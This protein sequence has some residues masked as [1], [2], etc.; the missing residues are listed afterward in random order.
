MFQ[1]GDVVVYKGDDV[2]SPTLPAGTFGIVVS[3][4]CSTVL[5]EFGNN[6]SGGNQQ[7]Y[8]GCKCSSGW[9][10][11][12]RYLEKP[13]LNPFYLVELVD[14]GERPY[15]TV[16]YADG[17]EAA[18]EAKR[19]SKDLGRKIQVR[20]IIDTPI[21]WKAREQMRFDMGL[22]DPMPAGWDLIP[23]KDHFLH[24]AKGDKGMVAYTKDDQ[25]GNLDR[26]ARTT[27]GR[28][29]ERFYPDLNEQQRARFIAVISTP[30]YAIT[31][32]PAAIEIIYRNGP[33]SCMSHPLNNYQSEIHP[34]QIYGN[35]E[36]ALAYIGNPNSKVSARA[37]VRPT[38]KAFY[39]IYG[40][41]PRLAK[42]LI[43][44]GYVQDITL[45]RG[46]RLPLIKSKKKPGG[47][48]I[49]Y[50]DGFSVGWVDD[51]KEQIVLGEKPKDKKSA[52]IISFNASGIAMLA[53][54]CQRTG[55]QTTDPLEVVCED[56][57]QLWSRAAVG[58]FASIVY[59]GNGKTDERYYD[60][61]I[62]HRV[63]GHTSGWVTTE[64]LE[65]D[66]VRCP[67]VAHYVPRSS[68]VHYYT[69]EMVSRAWLSKNG[70]VCAGNGIGYPID[71]A[72]AFVDGRRFSLEYLGLDDNA[73]NVKIRRANTKAAIENSQDNKQYEF[74][75]EG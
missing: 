26:Q 22:Y 63:H 10:I 25:D 4:E 7:V 39:R 75:V 67:K 72:M 35:S 16:R 57:V 59:D 47:V 12:E 73:V 64:I 20:R 5:V 29:L 15:S 46:A 28:Y 65:R 23:I 71:Q 24:I 66:F 17:K 13:N 37:I 36:L 3:S 56:G 1:I 54:T 6:W 44:D 21:D 34:T 41:A 53:V 70:F 60:Q 55:E 31:R 9:W 68:I 50:V 19:L 69:G 52:P 33:R 62:L 38:K 11:N 27:P 8:N 40:D 32:D 18:A 74:K 61:R 49:P 14:G 43:D 42:A 58:R 51:E 45:F 30:D 2:D 48:I